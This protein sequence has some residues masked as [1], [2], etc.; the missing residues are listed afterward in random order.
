MSRLVSDQNQA[1]FFFESGLYASPT[2]LALQS[3]GLVQNHAIDE[4]EN[5]IAE[6]HLGGA[7]R[8]VG[9]FI[10]GPQDYTGT[11]TYYPQD[12]KMLVFALGSNVDATTGSSVHTISETNSG[13][14]N[15]FTSGTLCPFVSFTI[16]DAQQ[17]TLPTGLNFVR[18]LN[19][20]NLNN[21]SI[22]ASQGDIIECE[23]EYMAQNETFSSGTGTTLTVSSLKPFLWHHG[24]FHLPSGTTFQQVK[25]F[26]FSINNNLEGPHY[27]NGSR[28]IATPAPLNRDY[29]FAITLDAVGGDTKTLYKTYFEGG[30]TFNSMMEVTDTSTRKLFIVMSGCRMMDMD[31]PTPNEGAINEQTWTIQPQSV[32]AIATDAVAK[33]NPW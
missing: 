33:Y 12:W 3:F 17:I 23:V 7:S 29:E 11:V 13:D 1:G 28:V 19:G 18:T 21:Y 6:R 31:A 15:A 22:S 4:N 5:I 25:S 26:D 8:N 32:S 14:R 24:Q 10:N 16:E 27:I 2:G 20:C 30:S 9:Q